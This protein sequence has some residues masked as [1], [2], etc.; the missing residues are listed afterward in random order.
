MDAGTWW[1]RDLMDAETWELCALV[2][3]NQ[4]RYEAAEADGRGGR[5]TRRPDERGDLM[6]AGA[7]EVCSLVRCSQYR[8]E[9]AGAGGRKDLMDAET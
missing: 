1:T 8:H 7:C 6:D 9:A 3:C 4:Y 5:R 2:R